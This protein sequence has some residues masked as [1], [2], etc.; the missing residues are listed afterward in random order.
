M[1]KLWNKEF[2][3]CMRASGDPI[4]AIFADSITI[5]RSQSRTDSILCA[6]N[7][8]V[9]ELNTFLMV[10]WMSCSVLWSILAV[11]SSKHKTLVLL[12]SA[13]TKHRSCLCPQLKSL[14]LSLMFALRP[15]RLRTKDSKWHS[16]KECQISLSEYWLRGSRLSF[17]VP[18]NRNGSWGI[19]N[20][21]DLNNRQT[22]YI[23]KQNKCDYRMKTIFPS[24]YSFEV[25]LFE[26]IHLFY[27]L[28]YC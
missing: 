4:S 22:K 16:R 28:A 20:K 15:P 14:P 6:T 13:L 27:R 17:I 3:F 11:A 9:A 26:T 5:M 1:H 2:G 23:I 8:T 21:L 19:M 18:L 7:R 10:C 12:S 24:I 25:N